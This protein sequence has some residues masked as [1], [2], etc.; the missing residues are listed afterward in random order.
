MTTMTQMTWVE[1]KADVAPKTKVHL[2]WNDNQTELLRTILKIYNQGQPI[3][4]DATYSTGA[5]WKN[6]PEPILKFDIDPQIP[7]VERADARHLPLEDDSIESLMIDLPFLVGNSREGIMKKRFSKIRDMSTLKSLYNDVIVEA[8]R[9]LEPKGILV[10]KCQDAVSSA[11]KHPISYNVMGYA[12]GAGLVY[13]DELILVRHNPLSQE[14]MFKNGQ[15][16]TQSALCKFFIFRNG[17]LT[18]SEQRRRA[19]EASA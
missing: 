9:V 3:D 10:F 18:I 17:R 7:G 2:S 14:H 15:Q 11:R 8:S 4:C 16:H 19:K 6:L 13:E 12:I 1:A 5:F